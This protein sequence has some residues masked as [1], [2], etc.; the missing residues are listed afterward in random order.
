[1]TSLCNLRF[2]LRI[3]PAAWLFCA[4][5]AACLTA[6]MAQTSRAQSDQ[7][8]ARPYA[9]L[10][11]E[12]TRREGFEAWPTR[13]EPG[14]LLQALHR[15]SDITIGSYFSGQTPGILTQNN[16]ERFDILTDVTPD[17]P[18]ALATAPRGHGLAIAHHR[19]FGSNAVFPLGPD[20]FDRISG[21]GEGSLAVLFDHDQRATGFLVH[22][23][24]P[25]P[26]GQRNA[27]RG[28]V[29]VIL[30]ARDGQV[31][32]TPVTPLKQGITA[33]GYATA[34]GAP[35]IA[36]MVILNT[37]PGGIAIDDI[38]YDRAALSGR[39]H[40]SGANSMQASWQSGPG[41]LVLMHA[42]QTAQRLPRHP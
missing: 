18:L 32:A 3:A 11:R 30:L 21:R 4:V 37:D 1:M 14:H 27:T 41:A 28:V 39:Q 22:A 40:R 38:L 15:G 7:I 24:Y 13:P 31:L 16:N 19:G 10:A 25:D 6:I 20:G 29:T 34:A 26:L 12:L 5:L 36:G 23:D 33:I 17:L 35:G 42:W 2:Y 8:L 9:D